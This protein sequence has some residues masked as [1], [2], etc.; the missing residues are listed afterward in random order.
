[1][2]VDTFM[3]EGFNNSDSD[4]VA[5]TR[6]N[7]VKKMKRRKRKKKYRKIQH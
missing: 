4:S 6:K 2:D 3:R 1:M 5:D 7:K